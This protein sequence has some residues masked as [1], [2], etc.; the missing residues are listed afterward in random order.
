M[1]VASDRY[2]GSIIII[3]IIIKRV[4]AFHAILIIF[5]AV[6]IGKVSIFISSSNDAFRQVTPEFRSMHAFLRGHSNE[7]SL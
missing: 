1:I 7:P 4:H 5:T 6:T 2:Y 3:I